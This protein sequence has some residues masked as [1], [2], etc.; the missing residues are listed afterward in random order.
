MCRPLTQCT[1]AKSEP[2]QPHQTRSRNDQK[3]RL[4]KTIS[5]DPKRSRVITNDRKRSQKCFSPPWHNRRAIAR[6]QTALPRP[7]TRMARPSTRKLYIHSPVARTFFCYTVCLRTFAH[8]HACAHTRMA[9]AQVVSKRCLLHMYHASPSCLLYLMFHPS[10]L[11][12]YIHFDIPF[13]STI[14]PYFPVLK[15]QDMCNSR[16]CIEEFG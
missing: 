12:L 5:N 6:H 8:L 16:T 14:L 11:F 10:L 13:Q 15:A 3:R 4:S 1:R 2:I 7:T 9:Q